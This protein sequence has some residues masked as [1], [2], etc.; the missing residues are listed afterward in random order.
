MK[1]QTKP[2]KSFKDLEVYQNSYE[3][4]LIV[5]KQ[6]I[7]KLPECEKY[8]LISQLSRACKAIPRLIAE[9]YAKR[10]QKA[11][12]QKYID[13]AMGESNEMIVSLE[14]ARD[15]YDIDSTLIEKLVDLYDKIGRQLYN[16][17]QSWINFKRSN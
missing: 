10:H 3:A 15:L 2:I 7:T 17:G 13:D 1:E 14:Q 11:G 5:M 4:M 16:L 8:D 6:V 12:F 9:G